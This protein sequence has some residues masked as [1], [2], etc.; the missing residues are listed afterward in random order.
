MSD[1][2]REA[3]QILP[4]FALFTTVLL[5]VLALVLDIGWGFT[6]RRDAQNG[7]DFAAVAGTR[8]IGQAVSGSTRTQQ[9]V[10]D[11]ISAAST[12][13]GTT[14][15]F[16][17]PSG[18]VYTD[19]NGVDLAGPVYVAQASSSIPGTARGVHVWASRSWQPYLLA[20]I[21]QTSM[22]A[23]SEAVARTAV[24]AQPQCAFCVIGTSPL[25][26]MQSGQTWLTVN[27]GGIGS[28]AGLDCSANAN[29]QSTGTGSG[30]TIYGTLMP[31]NCAIVPAPTGLGTLIPDPLAF[32]PNATLPAGP[33]LGRAD[34][35]GPGTNV[36]L[37]PGIYSGSTIEANATLNLNPGTYYFTGD[38]SIQSNGSLIGAGVTLVF[39]GPQTSFLPQSNS[40]I[41][42]SAP[43]PT[44][45]VSAAYPF[46]GMAIYFARDNKGTL[47]LQSSSTTSVTGTIYAVNA[48][49]LLDMQSGTTMGTLNSLVVVGSANLQSS[50]KLTVNYDSSQNVQ[51]PAGPPQLVK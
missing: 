40:T 22:K 26:T 36:T 43:P 38:M 21:G 45:P 27:G 35:K 25:F 3:G 7:A 39:M 1:R 34:A 51:L 33:N 2:T 32:L 41:S 6:Q 17:A 19:G 9:D 20:L 29:L 44:T 49:S 31:G 18:P 16:G 50:S 23:S 48:N 15:T 10:A 11:A 42:L 37:N 30:V 28:N 5:L 47:Q 14:V 12:A 46:P 8:V 4:L 13:N 24:G